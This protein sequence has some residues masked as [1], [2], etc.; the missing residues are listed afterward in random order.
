MANATIGMPK[1]SD[2]QVFCEYEE[3]I[4]PFVNT[5]PEDVDIVHTFAD[6]EALIN[7][8]GETFNSDGAAVDLAQEDQALFWIDV[9]SFFCDS[10]MKGAG[11]DG[12]DFKLF[13]DGAC[14]LNAAGQVIHQLY[15][16]G[17]ATLG[18]SD[19]DPSTPVVMDESVVWPCGSGGRYCIKIKR[20]LDAVAAEKARQAAGE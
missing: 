17:Q 13:S 14:V 2:S 15:Q 8:S 16:G 4:I 20:T 6:I 3:I 9:S 10:V 7:A 5:G 11:E 18:D 12:A 19:L 1:A